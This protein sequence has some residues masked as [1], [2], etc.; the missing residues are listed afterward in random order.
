MS[1]YPGDREVAA[2]VSA[3]RSISKRFA[4]RWEHPTVARHGGERKTMDNPVVGEITLD[5]D[6]FSLH[7]DD[8]PVIVFTATPGTP[9][10]D[11]LAVLNRVARPAE[12]RTLDG[13]REGH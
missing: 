2:M 4:A 6:V 3:L 12:R 10:A 1:R 7:G 13:A 8:L 9:D 11:K 5:C